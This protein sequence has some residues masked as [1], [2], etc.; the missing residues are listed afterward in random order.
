MAAALLSLSGK[1]N[2]LGKHDRAVDMFSCMKGCRYVPAARENPVDMFRY[3]DRA[4][5]TFL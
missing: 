2:D 1:R 5:D 4:V 3:M